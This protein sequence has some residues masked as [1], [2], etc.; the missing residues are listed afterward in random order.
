[1]IMI[2]H[3]TRAQS[4][5]SQYRHSSRGSQESYDSD[6]SG[7]GRRGSGFS[8][9]G[10]NDYLHSTYEDSSDFSGGGVG[11]TQQAPVDYERSLTE[12][13]PFVS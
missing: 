8:G 7:E 11:V 6:Y 10:D 12:E 2:D 5:E 13:G 9:L 1:M 4:R 3:S